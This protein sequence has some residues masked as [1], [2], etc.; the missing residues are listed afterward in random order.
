MKNRICF[1]FGH[2][3]FEYGAI[4]KELLFLQEFRR[5]HFHVCFV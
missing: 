3:D 1:S 5:Y 2:S 4:V